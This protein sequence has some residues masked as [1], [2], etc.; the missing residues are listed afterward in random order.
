MPKIRRGP[1]QEVTATLRNGLFCLED[2]FYIS[3]FQTLPPDPF[4]LAEC[5][6]CDGE[7]PGSAERQELPRK[8][9]VGSKLGSCSKATEGSPGC[10]PS[11]CT[12]LDLTCVTA[13]HR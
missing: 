2:S 7:V 12:P 10:S 6:V 5:N 4:P 8:M 13:A 9:A 1:L 11:R 3:C